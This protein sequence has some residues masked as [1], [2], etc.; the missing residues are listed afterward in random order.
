MVESRRVR[1]LCR[2]LC[3]NVRVRLVWQSRNECRRDTYCIKGR[4]T[5]DRLHEL[6]NDQRRLSTSSVRD[7]EQRRPFRKQ[8]VWDASTTIYPATDQHG[9]MRLISTQRS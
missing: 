8:N 3:C 9:R 1:E 4:R 7:G 6:A 5:L 2:G